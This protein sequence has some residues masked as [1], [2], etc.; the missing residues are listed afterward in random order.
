V[1]LLWAATI[2]ASRLPSMFIRW[3]PMTQERCKGIQGIL[4][5]RESLVSRPS[6]LEAD[7][8]FGRVSARLRG[9]TL[10]PQSGFYP[11]CSIQTVPKMLVPLVERL[12]YSVTAKALQTQSITDPKG[13]ICLSGSEFSILPLY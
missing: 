11:V 6:L 4:E 1:G 3:W 8:H 10:A 13:N 9:S 7:R 12:P 5:R 2:V